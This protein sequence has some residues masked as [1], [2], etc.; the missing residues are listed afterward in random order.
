MT[1]PVQSGDLSEFG[2]VCARIA[3]AA[4]EGKFAERPAVMGLLCQ[5]L[6]SVHREA[7]GVY[8]MSRP[9]NM[10]HTDK[11]LISEA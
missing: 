10:S 8:S 1:W 11:D 6:E 7:R 4:C 2:S 3:K 9:R 5:C